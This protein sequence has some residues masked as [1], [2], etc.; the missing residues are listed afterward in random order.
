MQASPTLDLVD[1]YHRFVIAFFDVISTSAPHIYHSALPLSPKT[2]LVRKHYKS[3]AH[4]LAKVV[5][6]LPVSWQP[7]IAT[8]KHDSRTFLEAAWSPCGRVIAVAQ[9]NPGA[10]GVLDPATLESLN[11]FSHFLAGSQWLCF[12]PDSGLLGLFNGHRGVA[13]W[14]LQTGGPID[15]MPSGPHASLAQYFSSTY[16]AD[17]KMVAIAYLVNT[18]ATAAISIYDLLFRTHTHTHHVLERHIVASIWT[19]GDCLRFATVKPG[20]ITVWEAVFTSKD[21]PVPV[22]SLPAPDN[23]DIDNLEEFLFLPALSRLAFTLR[24]AVM[25]WDAQDSKL[26]LNFVGANQS[27]SMSFSP[28]GRFFACGTTGQEVYLWKDGPNGYVLHQKVTSRSPGCIR[29]LLSPDGESIIVFGGSTLQL[30]RTADPIYSLPNTPTQP[31]GCTDFIL[32]R[33]PDGTLSAVARREESTVTV[34][35]LRPGDPRLII[36]TG[37]KILGLRVTESTVIVVDEGKVVTWN[38]PAKDCAPNT[39]MNIGDSTRTT[40]FDYPAMRRYPG[41][42]SGP[43]ASVSPD[44]NH[45]AFANCTVRTSQ[46]LNI[47]DASTGKHL[48]GTT[49]QGYEPW[50]T[51]DGREVRCHNRADMMEQYAIVK[52]SESGLTRLMFL[53]PNQY[54]PRVVPWG[55]SNNYQVTRNGWVLS[56]G[57]RLLWLPHHWR[58]EGKFRT[59]DGRFLGLLHPELP[60]AVILELNE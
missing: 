45:V 52:D 53:P 17:G 23:I 9:S 6:G 31:A 3:Y 18:T 34:L 27:E 15:A 5:H 38:L 51:S 26:L 19:R 14:D 50:F 54:M 42:Q 11:T 55:P 1:D 20:S 40:V 12:S 41:P 16:S 33:S 57:K 47:Y 13:S 60:E 37:M 2:S 59:W 43:H 4:P 32:E 28:N 44:L 25:V 36:D 7:G 35:D 39:R 30:W 24:E 29:P 10:V 48:T 8:K 21:A 49:V 58:S 22:E 46:G 56:S